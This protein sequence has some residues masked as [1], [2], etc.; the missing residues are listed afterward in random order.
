MFWLAA[1]A[2]LLL[3]AGCQTYNEK[4]TA[5]PMWRSGNVAAAAAEFTRIAEDNRNNKDTVIWRLEQ[6]YALHAAANYPESLKAFEAAEAKIAQYDERAKVKLS[7]ETA[8]LLSNQANL[9]YEGRDYDR[10]LLNAYKA[11]DHLA[12]GQAD[13]ARTELIR[14]YQRQQDAVANNRKRI[15]REAEEIN[16]AKEQPDAELAARSVEQAKADPQVAGQLEAHY[17][18]LNSLKAYA[19]Y[20]NPFPV[21]L[22]GI[23]FLHFAADASDR[24]RARKSF[25]RIR[26]LVG[27]SPFIR[28]DLDIAE[29]ATQGQAPPPMTYVIFETGS[30]PWR[31]QFR[32]DLPLFFVG[33]GNV[34]YVGAAFPTLAFDGNYA[35]GLSVTADAE[36]ATT[37]TLASMDS[38]V[39]LDFKNA[40]AGIT[41]KTLLAT[42]IKAAGAYAI[43]KAASDQDPMLGLLFKVVTTATQAAMNIADTRTWTTLPK[44]YQFCSVPTPANQRIELGL[45]NGQRTSLAV[46]TNSVN[47]IW[48]R[49]INPSAPLIVHV[50]K[51]K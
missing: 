6:G 19:D 32:I 26:G 12:L 5:V 43:N 9:P 28:R 46:G 15:E 45:A 2:V 42:T 22:D 31:E 34:P 24:E 10:V 35:S 47:L 11:L 30:A 38:V 33:S 16:R 1:C 14:A 36:T 21:Y 37:V 13:S 44:E 25:E 18:N 49:S 48:V 3:G 8:A 17:G 40:I 23:F 27:D 4:N 51:L 29:K 39:G 20:V 7:N 50:T 41:T